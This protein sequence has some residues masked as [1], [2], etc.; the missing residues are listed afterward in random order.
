VP[1]NWHF[2]A[3]GERLKMAESAPIRIP[4]FMAFAG[5]WNYASAGYLET[6]DLKHKCHTIVN[7]YAIMEL[8]KG[9]YWAYTPFDYFS[10]FGELVE[11][12]H[13]ILVLN[14]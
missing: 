13:Q 9:K 4:L 12:I 3:P 1:A 5:L 14:N 8:N 11:A 6:L 7:E 10:E 2:L